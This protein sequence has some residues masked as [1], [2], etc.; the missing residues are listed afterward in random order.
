MR[1]RKQ[2][3]RLWF[4]CL[5]ICLNDNQYQKNLDRSSVFYEEWG[6]VAGIKFDDWWKEHR[7]LFEDSIVREVTRVS[8]NP[9]TIAVS[10]P[11]DEKVSTILKHVKSIVEAHQTNKLINMGL[12]PK[13]MKSLS[14]GTSKYSFTQKE[15]KGKFHYINLEMY[16]FYL[17]VGRPPINRQFLIDIRTHFDSRTRSKLRHNIIWIPTIPDFEK[18]YPTNS[19]LDYV[20][21]TVRRGLKSV[22]KTLINVSNGQFP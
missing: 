5:Q 14:L 16:K 4:E 1:S 13:D 9:N 8:K 22:E 7:Y 11:L 21:R 15:M 12:D 10:I 2:H 3:I 18:Y 19:S 6:T 20:I 17:S